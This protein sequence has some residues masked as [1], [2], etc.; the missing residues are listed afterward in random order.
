[1]SGRVIL[2]SDIATLVLVGATL[3]PRDEILV[4]DKATLVLVG[5]TFGA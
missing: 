4:T 5:A 2:V 3:V 1:M